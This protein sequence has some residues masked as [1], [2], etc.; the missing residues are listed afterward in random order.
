MA[1]AIM[2]VMAIATDAVKEKTMIEDAVEKKDFKA[3]GKDK[4]R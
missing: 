3:V 1:I 4:T 2:I